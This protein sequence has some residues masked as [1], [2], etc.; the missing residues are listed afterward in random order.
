MGPVACSPM[1]G[2]SCSGRGGVWK[3]PWGG[4]AL[5]QGDIQFLNS[6]DLMEGWGQWTRA[7]QGELE[8]AG[9]QK[10]EHRATSKV[11]SRPFVLVWACSGISRIQVLIVNFCKQKVK[12]HW[13]LHMQ[14]LLSSR[15]SRG[16]A[17]KKVWLPVTARE[18]PVIT[19]FRSSLAHT[20]HLGINRKPRGQF[21][22]LRLCVSLSVIFQWGQPFLSFACEYF[23]PWPWCT[24]R[25]ILVPRP[26]WNHTFCTGSVES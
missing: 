14:A 17:F 18:L 21:P 2:D 19:G 22:A 8:R 7:G 1:L 3:T 13:W 26:G 24:A 5:S 4:R 23:F 9:K 20:L 11:K 10:K 12:G 25:G 16:T 15:D 6:R